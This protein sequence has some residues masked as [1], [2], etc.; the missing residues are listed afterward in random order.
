DEF[1][2]ELLI[3]GYEIGDV[4]LLILLENEKKVTTEA[5]GKKIALSQTELLNAWKYDEVSRDYVEVELQLRGLTT[6]E[7][8]ILLNTKEKQWGLTK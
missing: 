8:N 5:G 3:R 6:D 2:N 4:D 7:V 1:R